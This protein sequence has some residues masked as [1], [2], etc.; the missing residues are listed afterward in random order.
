MGTLHLLREELA[1][2]GV[3]NIQNWLR[4]PRNY[5]LS[6][7][8]VLPMCVGVEVVEVARF[9]F[10]AHRAE[11]CA[12]VMETVVHYLEGESGSWCIDEGGWG[13]DR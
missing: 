5:S 7:N 4:I 12:G 13:S 10:N 3:L 8:R 6:D 1:I 2:T 9:N 11:G